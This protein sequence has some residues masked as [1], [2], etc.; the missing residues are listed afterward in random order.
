MYTPTLTIIHEKSGLAAD[1]DKTLIDDGFAKELFSRIDYDWRKTGV[2]ARN[3]PAGTARRAYFDHWARH[4]LALHDSAVVLHL[5]C[6]LDDL[7]F[8]LDPGPDVEWYDVDYREVIALVTQLYPARKH[9]HPVAASVTDPAWLTDIPGDRP[10][11]LIAQGLTYYLTED[12]GIALLRRVVEHF[13]SGEMCFDVWNWLSIKL[14]K[15]NPVVRHSGATL[16]WAVNEPSDILDAVP[17]VRLLEAISFF[18]TDEFKQL[19]SA[20][21]RALGKMMRA[22]PTLRNVAQLHRYA[23]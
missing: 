19:P 18:E 13:P 4:F 11:L 6:G 20:V 12:D 16:H 8:R 2:T 15:L 1:A 7:V 23:F 17:G 22:V 14:Q 5:G 10:V 21:Y 9:Y 3:A